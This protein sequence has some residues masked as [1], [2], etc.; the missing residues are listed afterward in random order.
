MV[1]TCNEEDGDEEELEEHDRHEHRHP[2]PAFSVYGLSAEN[3][4]FLNEG[5]EIYQR[6][7]GVFEPRIGV[8]AIPFLQILEQPRV[9]FLV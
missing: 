5:L 1:G 7:I 8:R 6:R 4:S 9:Q 3:W 2:V